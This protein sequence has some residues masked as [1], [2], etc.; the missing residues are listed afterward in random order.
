VP[1]K[2]EDVDKSKLIP[3]DS[4]DSDK[5]KNIQ[6]RYILE[7]SVAGDKASYHT[8]SGFLSKKHP[9]GYYLPCCF[10][11]KP[12]TGKPDAREKL[13][14]AALK[15]Y[16]RETDNI[17]DKEK[18][19]VVDYIQDGLKFPLTENRKGHLTLILERFFDVK[20]SDCY[21]NLQKKKLKLN[22][23]CLLRHGVHEEQP[24]LS[25]LSFIY[26]KKTVPLSEFITHI[27]S[28]INVDNILMFHNGGLV[29]TFSKNY[30]TQNIDTYKG[31]KLYKKLPLNAF[32]QL[33]NGY[34]MFVKYL[35]S[36]DYIDYTYLWDIAT[37]VLFKEKVNM[38]VLKK[39][40]EDST[41]NLHIV[42][43]TTAHAL[44]SFHEKKPSILIYQ[45]GDF[46]EPLYIYK[47][48]DD[49]KEKEKVIT[50]FDLKEN[51][52]SINDI[53]KKIHQNIGTECKE[54]TVHGKYTF[55]ENLYLHEL[56]DE[57]KKYK[58]KTGKQIMNTDGR[59]F[60]LMVS[61]EKEKAFFVP[62]KPSA[63]SGEY[64]LYDDDIWE[65]YRHT[66][67]HLNKLA[68]DSQHRI[69]CKPKIRILENEMVVGILTETN[70]FVQLKEPEE[71]KMKD[72]LVSVDEENRLKVEKV[73]Q[74]G[75]VRPKDK[76][77]QHLKLEQ[78]FYNA[79][80]NTLKV[81]LNDSENLTLRKK[82]EKAIQSRD[83]RKVK[84]LFEPLMERKFL[85]VDEYDVD[86]TTLNHINLCKNND[87][88]YC[89][90][91]EHEGKLLLPA[92][93]LFNQSD[94]S[95]MYKN[96]F[97]DDLLMNIHTQRILFEEIHSTL[98][99]TDRYLLNDDEILL[100]ES[101]LVNYLSKE[102]VKKVASVMYTL[103]EDIQPSK[104]LEYIEKVEPEEEKIPFEVEKE[105]DLDSESESEDEPEPE[106]EPESEPESEP[107]DEPEPETDDE[108]EPE[109]EP[110]PESVQPKPKEVT[111]K[112]KTLPKSKKVI[113]KE[114]NL[115]AESLSHKIS[116]NKKVRS[117]EKA[118]VIVQ[119]AKELHKKNK[120]PASEN[121]VIEAQE[122]LQEIQPRF[123]KIKK[124]QEDIIP[125]IKTFYF[126]KN[127]KWKEYFPP[128]TI[129]FRI[130]KGDTYNTAEIDV[131]C[132]FIMALQILKDYDD[133]YKAMTLRELKEG[134]VSGY[135]QLTELVP[136]EKK[137]KKEKE[138][139]KTF[140]EILT[141]RYPFTQLDL[142]V[143]MFHYK[144]PIVLFIQA[145]NKINLITYHTKDTFKYYIK[146]KK[147][148]VFMFFI[149]QNSF[150]IERSDMDAL[151][152]A[153][154]NIVYLSQP[155]QMKEFFEKY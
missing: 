112:P 22:Y 138:R 36:K 131:K 122:H 106:P 41:Q 110:E 39:G 80:F 24:F 55:K 62:C 124:L 115:N 78:M 30:E 68:E 59:I 84:D 144:L 45:E 109:P 38:I 149:Y 81:E 60:G 63:I 1:V 88:P 134:L 104:I 140:D 152:H 67:Q 127:S 87:E 142:L 123:T 58:Y 94:N 23:P 56:L 76:V 113:E 102:P 3:R 143:L 43:P 69:P 114:V 19:K 4:S 95:E 31:A 96:R 34:E 35:K 89:G 66:V 125:C 103:L 40:M 121:A 111:K 117:K 154:R 53:L 135:K 85:F 16:Q 8:R 33:V 7:L 25:T 132:N 48:T 100:L 105:I 75:E 47:K 147:K 61:K 139:Y 130:M 150:Q 73:I 86:I 26:Y 72:D 70:Q 90:K 136:M 141:E 79:Y 29:K 10:K 97:I 120:S 92:I 12:N 27:I 9:K 50:V 15:Y 93:N 107:E 146:M 71:N 148:D 57:L 37:Q 42:C 119:Q 77:I 21:S 64:M 18:E 52:P 98:Y 46:F 32:K 82:I 28:K 11:S 129:G 99:Y 14:V 20:S 153:E 108:P 6:S 2:P 137:F 126:K 13:T 74:K 17:P 54:K 44:Y 155:E 49:K 83:S 133:Q 118:E 51:I 116:E 91:F 128:K 101:D 65:D 5:Q 151:Y 145:K